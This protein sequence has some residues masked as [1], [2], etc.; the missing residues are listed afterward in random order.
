MEQLETNLGAI[1]WQLSDTD[2]KKLDTLSAIEL[3]YP[4]NLT[5]AERDPSRNH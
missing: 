1:G 5:S 2:M 4:W 3:P